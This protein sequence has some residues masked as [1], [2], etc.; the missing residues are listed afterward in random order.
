MQRHTLEDARTLTRFGLFYLTPYTGRLLS[1]RPYSLP[2]DDDPSCI[3]RYNAVNIAN[4][5]PTEE[6]RHGIN[7]LSQPHQGDMD[8]ITGGSA[9]FRSECFADQQYQ[10]GQ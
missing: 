5:H 1:Q 2:L 4:Y 8:L 3:S 10:S 7:Y 6:L 9:R